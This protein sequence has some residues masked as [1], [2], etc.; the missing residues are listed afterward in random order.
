MCLLVALAL[1]G[2]FFDMLHTITFFHAPSV[3]Q[4]FR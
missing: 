4:V 3:A 2:V 1:F